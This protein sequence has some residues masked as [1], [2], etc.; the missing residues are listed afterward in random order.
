METMALSWHVDGASIIEDPRFQACSREGV[1]NEG[2]GYID[3][4]TNI[5][6][7]C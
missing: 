1:K 3:V 5:L 2:N 7:I 6:Y 4:Y